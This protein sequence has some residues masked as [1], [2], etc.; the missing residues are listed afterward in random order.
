MPNYINKPS[1]NYNP[2]LYHKHNS[3]HKSKI[4]LL[5]YHHKIHIISTKYPKSSHNPILKI[6]L[7]QHYT[8]H[9]KPYLA[10]IHS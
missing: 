5:H 3:K 8:H 1:T 7:S 2:K 10:K 9:Y 4:N 6:I